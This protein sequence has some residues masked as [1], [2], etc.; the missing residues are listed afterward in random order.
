[1]LLLRR[2]L[3]S[4][5]EPR[6]YLSMERSYLSLVKFLFI[7]FA[8]GILAKKFALLLMVLH[9][10]GL[11]HV[12]ND[13]YD[14]LTWPSLFLLYTV[15]LLFASDLRYVDRGGVVAAREV[16]DPRVYCSA[17]R[18]LLSWLRTGISIMVF[19]FVIE[20][21]DFFLS[22]L[23]YILHKKIA[24]ASTFAGMD[25]LFIALGMIT[26]I[27]G[28]WSFFTT[29]AQVEAGFYRPHFWIYGVYGLALL[30]TLLGMTRL[31][32]MLGFPA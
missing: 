17:E 30:L 18:T 24:M 32:W 3:A 12:F 1:V 28:F 6:L 4:V 22:K 19:G 26:L 10:P 14:L 27:C 25:L 23:A 2:S 20:K 7:A 15:F 9:L 31:L 8:A 13:L 11:L 29:L 5:R 16:E 21:F